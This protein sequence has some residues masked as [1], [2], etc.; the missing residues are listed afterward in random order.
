MNISCRWRDDVKSGGCIL[1]RDVGKVF[2]APNSLHPRFP[3]SSSTTY[4]PPHHI[5]HPLNPWLKNIPSSPIRIGNSLP[6]MSLQRAPSKALL[7]S[8]R[9]SAL[10]PPCL[11]IAAARQVRWES[12]ENKSPQPQQDGKSFRGQLYNSTAMR[13]QREKADRERFSQARNE[14]S[15][16]RSLALTFGM[17]CSYFPA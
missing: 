9:R 15:G 11:R 16:G 10:L 5:R 12:T 4:S 8:L 3:S 13:L 17:F 1:S 7:A 14:S 6:T 2:R